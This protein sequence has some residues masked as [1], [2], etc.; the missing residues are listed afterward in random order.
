MVCFESVGEDS[1]FTFS[2]L[3]HGLLCHEMQPEQRI[4]EMQGEKKQYL[5]SVAM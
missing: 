1:Y 2:S 3:R 4:S 5:S